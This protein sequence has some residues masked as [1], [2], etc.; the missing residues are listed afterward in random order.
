[1]S[2][3]TERWCCQRPLCFSPRA[4]SPEPL[5]VFPTHTGA[6]T[7]LQLGDWVPR[8]QSRIFQA[9]LALGLELAQS[10]HPDGQSRHWTIQ[11]PM[12]GK[13][14]PSLHGRLGG[15][16]RGRIAGHPE[17]GPTWSTSVPPCQ[18]RCVRSAVS[19]C[20]SGLTLQVS[21]VPHFFVPQ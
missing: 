12:E 5:H 7:F 6:W 9:S 19:V 20:L 1:M 3:A 11:I 4:L 13:E 18:F 15:P 10:L 16:G 14:T 8:S 2:L 21:S 17:R